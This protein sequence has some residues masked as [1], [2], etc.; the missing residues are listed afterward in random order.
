MLGTSVTQ[1]GTGETGSLGSRGV[2]FW[3]TGT[4]LASIIPARVQATHYDWRLMA[5]LRRVVS[6]IAQRLFRE[7]SERPIAP[8]ALQCVCVWRHDTRAPARGCFRLSSTA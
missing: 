2:T 6:A 8:G 7:E 5:Q 3:D 4:A 1:D